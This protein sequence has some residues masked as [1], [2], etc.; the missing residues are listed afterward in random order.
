MELYLQFGYGM[1]D[2]CKYLLSKWGKGT[3]ILSPRD[4]DPDKNQL[5]RFSQEFH[6]CNGSVLVD[7]QLFNPRANHHTLTKHTYWPANYVTGLWTGGAALN[8]LLE[9]IKLLNSKANSVGYIIPGLY[10]ERVDDDWLAVQETIID[11]SLRIMNDK[12][13]FATLCLS[14]ESIRFENQIETIINRTEEW[15]IAGYYIV[16]EHPGNQYLVEDPL[17]LANLL[18]LSSGLKLQGKKVIVGYSSH[19]MLCLATTNIDA[20]ASGSWLNIRSFSL[21]KFHDSEDNDTS[22]RAKWY[23]CPQALSEYKIP[24]LDLAYRAKIL[25]QM[26]PDRQFLSNTSDILFSG[27]QPSTVTYSEGDSFR[28]Y[29][30]CLQYQCTHSKR[31]TFRETVDAQ[32]IML[33]T[34]ER[35]I[36]NFHRHGVRG[37][38]RD[39]FNIID[40]N[41][42]AITM[43]EEAR[44]FVLERTWE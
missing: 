22:R 13:R 36:K 24:F 26:A 18:I 27:A 15:D 20:I 21:N 17:W 41:R 8:S 19:Q 25:G 7:P 39:F 14:A 11:A 3:V 10:C 42:A 2:H 35:F 37:Q 30:T 44:G 1:K 12:E 6:K 16:P 23:Y 34:A 38:D 32:T 43:L 31:S 9:E 28:H 29:L 5:I 4:L 40:V 33:E